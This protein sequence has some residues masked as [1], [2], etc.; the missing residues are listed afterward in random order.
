M[1]WQVFPCLRNIAWWLIA[2]WLIVAFPTSPETRRCIPQWFFVHTKR[3][4][5]GVHLG[6]GTKDGKLCWLRVNLNVPKADR[7]IQSTVPE[8]LQTTDPWIPALPEA[9]ICRT[10]TVLP[11]ILL[12]CHCKVFNHY[13]WNG[14]NP[15][16]PFTLLKTKYSW[17]IYV[18]TKMVPL[19]FP[20]LLHVMGREQVHGL[21]RNQVLVCNAAML[22]ILENC[23]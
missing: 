12:D 8:P 22:M 17:V 18:L 1:G 7:T 10:E 16:Y 23:S 11:G 5:F 3:G 15:L 19:P 20:S 21:F 2:I 6:Q 9:K 14:S 13:L 4:R